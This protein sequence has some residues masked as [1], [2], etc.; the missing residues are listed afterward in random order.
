VRGGWRKAERETYGIGM[1][2][3]VMEE[4]GGAIEIFWPR[5]LHARK[6]ALGGVGAGEGGVGGGGGDRV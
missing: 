5:C 1:D 3:R 4:V 2:G 6:N